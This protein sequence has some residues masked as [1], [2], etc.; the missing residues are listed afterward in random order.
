[1]GFLRKWVIEEEA[2]WIY[3]RKEKEQVILDAIV[4][5]DSL[6]RRMSSL[7]EQNKKL[8]EKSSPLHSDVLRDL[9][10]LKSKVIE[11]EKLLSQIHE[12]FI[13]QVQAYKPVQANL[14]EPI[15][16][17]TDKGKGKAIGI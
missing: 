2:K 12:P 17:V 7:K 1:M 5:R 15:V 13:T 16:K 8:S 10:S 4:E 14:V 3:S 6:L 11:Q 9:N